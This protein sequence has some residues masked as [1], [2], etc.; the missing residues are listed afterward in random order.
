MNLPSLP[1]RSC[2]TAKS[3]A[4]GYGRRRKLQATRGSADEKLLSDSLGFFPENWGLG[5]ALEFMPLIDYYW[6][7][8]AFECFSDSLNSPIDSILTSW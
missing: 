6:V 5:L 1:S 3:F 8:C 7:L 2:A 4:K